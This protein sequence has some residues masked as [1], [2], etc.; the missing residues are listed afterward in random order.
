MLRLEDQDVTAAEGRWADADELMATVAAAGRSVAWLNDENWGRAV[1]PPAE[2]ER[3]PARL[4]LPGNEPKF[5]VNAGLH[6]PDGVI[7]DLEDSV[8]PAEKDAARV[9]VRNSLLCVDFGGTERIVR[10]NPLSTEYGADDIAMVVP[11]G[12]DTIL[13]PK[14]DTADDVK[15]VEK[16]VAEGRV[17]QK[18]DTFTTGDTLPAATQEKD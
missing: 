17:I 10:I 2:P 5:Y 7:L 12:P 6:G 11:A 14:C 4:Y 3:E 9:L 18:H 16:L 15:A 1:A 13:I 8:A